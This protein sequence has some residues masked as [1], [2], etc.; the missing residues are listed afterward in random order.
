MDDDLLGGGA[1][2]DGAAV[3]SFDDDMLFG[4]G[5]EV[6]TAAET[7][8][9]SP[10]Q[11][12][13]RQ[14]VSAINLP[15]VKPT[16]TVLSSMC[17]LVGGTP[18][19]ARHVHVLSEPNEPLAK[20]RRVTVIAT[21]KGLTLLTAANAESVEREI[22]VGN[23]IGVILYTDD[24]GG[25]KL[26]S[27]TE[28]QM[29]MHIRGQ[30]DLLFSVQ[31]DETDPPEKS[32]VQV[33]Q[34]IVVILTALCVAYDMTLPVSTLRRET[35]QLIDF[36]HDRP[37]P[38]DDLRQRMHQALAARTVQY[39][40]H[41]GLEKSERRFDDRISELR[42]SDRGQAA[43]TVREEIKRHLEL[44][45]AQREQDA[46][47]VAD[48]TRMRAEL[49]QLQQDLKAE[50]DKRDA[51]IRVQASTAVNAL[52]RQQGK[53]YEMQK[54][55]HRRA[56]T[57]LAQLTAFCERAQRE[58]PRS[59]YDTAGTT[60]H[61]REMEAQI[62]SLAQYA[63]GRTELNTKVVRAL[64]ENRKRL[65]AAKELLAEHEGHLATLT[66]ATTLETI[67]SQVLVLDIPESVEPVVVAFENNTPPPT[68]AARG[69]ITLTP[70]PEP[71]AARPPIDLSDDDI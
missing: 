31:K 2:V 42:Q 60:Q 10:S 55:Q 71:A 63:T 12:P 61:M 26:S 20:R 9:P 41:A 17:S 69:A 24:E 65:N 51:A 33:S 48:L 52:A 28:I 11:S 15:P 49:A 58:R 36:F 53:A 57:R 64:T 62:A 13:V 23:I 32:V 54:G 18:Y 37:F 14:Q 59:E 38:D 68:S 7:A 34:G 40:E 67:N 56:M 70:D 45:A 47:T 43:Y 5:G 19:L 25:R 6:P 16:S 27:V 3:P 50:A 4:G 46:L 35:E 29:L 39:S 22:P 30:K 8:V 44:V 21:E 66:N 1:S